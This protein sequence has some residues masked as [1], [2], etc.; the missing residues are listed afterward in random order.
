M[1]TF[2]AVEI[3][4]EV[5]EKVGEYIDSLRELFD[6]NVKWVLPKNLHFT[7][8]FLGEI[9]ESDLSIVEDCVSRT[10]SDFEPFS[11]R[12]SSVGFFPSE[13]KP[14]VFWLGTDG[15][16]DR[17]IDVYQEL[18]SCLE[19][20]GFDRD[21]RTFSPH[22]TI[23]RVRKFKKVVIPGNAH[24]FEPVDFKVRRLSVIK[25]TLTPKGPVYE[26]LYEEPF[27]G[28]M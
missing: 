8:K 6:D 4:E 20:N 15:G 17:L 18:E 10:A 14:R 3:P 24:D 7:I 27:T 5:K 19:S 25:S 13:R 21:E 2:I 12:L 28:T 23:G 16:I 11:L 9:K 22:L 1:R 26:I